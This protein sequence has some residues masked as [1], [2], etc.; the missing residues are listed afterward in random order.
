MT[1]RQKYRALRY[2]QWKMMLAAHRAKRAKMTYEERYVEWVNR[3]AAQRK[4]QQIVSNPLLM[5]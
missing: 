5:P 1:K 3:V 4:A 2:R